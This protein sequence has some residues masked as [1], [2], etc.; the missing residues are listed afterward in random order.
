MQKLVEQMAADLSDIKSQLTEIHKV[1]AVN[2]HIMQVHERRSLQL[3]ERFKPVEDDLR[4]RA[5]ISSWVWAGGLAGVTGLLIS[6]A[7]W[8]RHS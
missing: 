3:E 2:T 7:Q 4:F 6:I 1:L 5:R 8:L